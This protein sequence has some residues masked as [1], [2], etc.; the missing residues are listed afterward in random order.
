M[1]VTL[2]DYDKISFKIFK[3]SILLEDMNLTYDSPQVLC[4]LLTPHT[5]P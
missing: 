4:S 2:F 1:L 3:N 5:L